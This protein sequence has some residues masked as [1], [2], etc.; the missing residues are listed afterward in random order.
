VEVRIIKELASSS[1]A[2]VEHK[3][4]K[5]A[6]R[7]SCIVCNYNFTEGIKTD[8][9]RNLK[10]TQFKCTTCTSAAALCGPQE[11]ECWKRWHEKEDA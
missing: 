7:R 5:M 9:R 6:K 2:Q 4:E 3:L 10:L 1:G 8:R 11:S